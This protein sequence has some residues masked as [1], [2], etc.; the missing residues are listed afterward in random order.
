MAKKTKSLLAILLAMFLI[1][2]CMP[3]ALAGTGGGQLIVTKFLEVPDGLPFTAA[4]AN[5]TEFKF[6]FIKVSLNGGSTPAALAA[7]PTLN[8]ANWTA[9]PLTGTAWPGGGGNTTYSISSPDL[10][11]GISW[12][13]Y[14]DGEYVYTV[15]EA[16]PAI[17]PSSYSID[18]TTGTMDYDTLVYTL[19]FAVLDGK[20]K[21]VNTLKD[22]KGHD[23]DEAQ[24]TNVFK[25]GGGTAPKAGVEITKNLVTPEGTAVQA[26]TSNPALFDFEFYVTPVQF[27]ATA[28]DGS[29]M[30]TIGSPVTPPPPG[31]GSFTLSPTSNAPSSSGGTSTYSASIANILAGVSWTTAGKYTY[32]V[33]E[34][35][36]NG[37]N[38]YTVSLGSGFTGTMN[39][40]T[41]VYTLVINVIADPGNPGNLI[42]EWAYCAILVPVLNSGGQ[43]MLDEG[44]E[45]I[46]EIEKTDP[47]FINEWVV[48]QEGGLIVEKEVDGQ[49]SDE[50]DWFGFE[51]SISTPAAI[52]GVAAFSPPNTNY[53]GPY[54]AYLYDET[55]QLVTSLPAGSPAYPA[56]DVIPMTTPYVGY[57]VAFTSGTP[58]TFYLK[59]GWTLEFVQTVVGSPYTVTELGT[60]GYQ[61]TFVVQPGGATATGQYGGALST[62]GQIVSWNYVDTNSYVLYVNHGD[63]IPPGGLNLNTLPFYGMLALAAALLGVYVAVKVRKRKQY[64]A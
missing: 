50:E 4:A 62:G 60:V 63:I 33:A 8:A 25:A 38:P 46:Y 21:V 13:S 42:V 36:P 47:I 7:M 28:Y 11:A 35:N 56:C 55:H 26:P 18:A 30:P 9:K 16:V 22:S 12:A 20:L 1:S 15:K 52:D 29:N 17:N 44:G 3:V 41:A 5:Q 2:V 10:L 58:A 40:S 59:H 27:N 49:Y 43:P 32:T 37:V 24:F 64:N 61:A 39:Y 53:Q 45:I 14:P 54:I 51:M 48:I 19:S 34:H 31:A 57:G 6:E 23:N